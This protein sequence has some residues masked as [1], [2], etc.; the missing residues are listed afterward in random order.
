M[1]L[2]LLRVVLRQVTRGTRY[3]PVHLAV[4]WPA[5]SP[6]KY[7]NV[8]PRRVSGQQPLTSLTAPMYDAAFYTGSDVITNVGR[9][10]VVTEWWWRLVGIRW[11][12][13]RDAPVMYVHVHT[14]PV[15]F[16]R[17][18]R[19][20]LR[21][22]HTKPLWHN[23]VV[24][25]LCTASFPLVHLS[26]RRQS[27]VALSHHLIHLAQSLPASYHLTQGKKQSSF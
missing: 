25:G 3:L 11:L 13:L 18:H 6:R 4:R 22:H 15:L 27:Q 19:C 16:D 23:P 1:L 10:S 2:L 14:E 12:S 17:Q 8:R 24:S 7:H 21:L 20:C 26:P 9:D 5:G